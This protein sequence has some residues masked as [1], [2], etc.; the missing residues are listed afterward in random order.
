[1]TFGVVSGVGREMDVLD[2]NGDR[3]FEGAVSGVN[4][5]RPILIHDLLFLPICTIESRAS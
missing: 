1:M 2:G 4:V 5:G 3:R